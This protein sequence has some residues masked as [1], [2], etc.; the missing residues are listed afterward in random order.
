M[1]S[2]SA[3]I[4]QDILLIPNILISPHEYLISPLFLLLNAPT[5]PNATERSR[6]PLG[7]GFE[8][9]WPSKSIIAQELAELLE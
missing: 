3:T 9:C 5:T 6:S 2:V 8:L 7:T 1:T 4:R